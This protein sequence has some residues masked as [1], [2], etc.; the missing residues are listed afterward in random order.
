M[1]R[2]SATV[3]SPASRILAR[4]ASTISSYADESNTTLSLT[5]VTLPSSTSSARSS[6]SI[7]LSVGGEYRLDASTPM[8]V[9]ISRC[10]DS[11]T[12]RT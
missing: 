8:Y 1:S 10:C 3:T 11:E 4:I 12:T 2:T 6:G 5:L 7:G 9:S